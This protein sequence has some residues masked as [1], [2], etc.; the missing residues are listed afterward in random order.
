MALVALSTGCL[1]ACD[2]QQASEASATIEAVSLL[3]DSLARPPVDSVLRGR[4]E[5]LLTAARAAWERAPNDVDSIVW[6][7]R[8][9]A[10]LGRYGEAIDLYT[11]GLAAHPDDPRLL[12]HR[13]HRLLSVRRID[14]AIAD[15]AR[16][17]NLT[18]GLPDEVEPDGLPNARNIPTSTLQSNIWYHLG[19]ARYVKGDLA[20]A[21]EAYERGVAV[22]SN[23]DMLTAMSYWLYLTERRLG[24][25]TAAAR[26][27]AAV[28][29]DFDIIENH[30]YHRLM[31]LYQGRLP[32]DSLQ[33]PG[34]PTTL[35]DV[36]TAYGVGAWHL[37]EGR[38]AQA[39]A[40]FRRIVAVRSQWPA[41]GYLAAEAE[42]AR[43]IGR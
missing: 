34:G 5:G 19:L 38:P 39:E 10:Y 15:F 1:A 24:D 30:G 6:L 23:P 4:Y 43:G 36:T 29:P 32:V 7:G 14:D 18:R 21:R 41:F 12:R 16:A 17:A 35:D 9:T 13:G 40:V 22:S 2:A 31:M 37:I 42:L 33:P 27:L 25:G 8:R 26:T 11:R 3:G 28:R 20:A